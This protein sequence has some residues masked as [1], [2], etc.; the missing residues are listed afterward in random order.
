MSVSEQRLRAYEADELLFDWV[1]STGEQGRPTRY[2]EFQVIEKIPEAWSSVW[3]LRMPHWLGIYWAGGSQNGI[4][5]LPINA[6]GQQLWA[7]FLGSRIS[8]GCIILDTP[9]AAQLYEWADIGTPV[10][11]VP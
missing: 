7:G 8:Y 1:C 11:V 9:N 4:H 6:D 5:G 10:A 3:G 2:G